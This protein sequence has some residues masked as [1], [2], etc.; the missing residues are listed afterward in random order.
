LTRG[1][2]SSGRVCGLVDCLVFDGRQAAKP[3]LARAVVSPLDPGD[4]GQPQLLA[5][6][7]A[8]AVQNVLLQQG[9]K[10]LHGTVIAAGPRLCSRIRSA[11]GWPAFARRPWTGTDRALS[12]VATPA[13]WRECRCSSRASAGVFQPSVLRGLT[14]SDAA[15]ASISLRLHRDKS[16]PSGKYWRRSPLVFSFVH[17]AKGC[18]GQRSRRPDWCRSSAGRAATPAWVAGLRLAAMIWIFISSTQILHGASIG[19]LPVG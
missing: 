11:R 9:E 1:L 3:A 6:G 17:A 10:R 19:M 8:L 5:A 7:P 12:V 15:T 14:F 16:V 18:V 13:C 2:G 4:D